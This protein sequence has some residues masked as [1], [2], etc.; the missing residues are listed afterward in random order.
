MRAKPFLVWINSTF[1]LQ[2]ICVGRF[3]VVIAVKKSKSDKLPS[4]S[5]SKMSK[6]SKSKGSKSKKAQSK[7]KPKAK[8]SKGIAKPKSKPKPNHPSV[9][10]MSYMYNPYVSECRCKKDFNDAMCDWC[11][12]GNENCID[13]A[14]LAKCCYVQECKCDDHGADVC[15][16]CV[17][18]GRRNGSCPSEECTA[19]CCTILKN[20]AYPASESNKNLQ[21][22]DYTSL[23]QWGNNDIP[24]ASV[25]TITQSYP[26]TNDNASERYTEVSHGLF[27]VVEVGVVVGILAAVLGIIIRLRRVRCC[28]I[29]FIHI[30]PCEHMGRLFLL[31]FFCFLLCAFYFLVFPHRI[32]VKRASILHFPLPQIMCFCRIY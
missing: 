2:T 8:S 19:L 1:A 4:K 31:S 24:S 32:Q 13:V 16:R 10:S 14:C 21:G 18:G 25:T 5:K 12:T 22:N 17:K 20:S 28:Y 27:A 11:F 9:S 30:T 26:S 23:S 7:S 15:N 3:A 29:I 6:G